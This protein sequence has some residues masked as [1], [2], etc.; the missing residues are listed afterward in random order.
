MP[1]EL[2]VVSI[3]AAN[4]GFL[5]GLEISQIRDYESQ[6]HQSLK[7]NSAKLLKIIQEK[8]SLSDEENQELLE[9]ISKFTENFLA[10]SGSS[11]QSA[12]Q[13]QEPSQK[14]S[15]SKPVAQRQA[16]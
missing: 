14:K 2:Q 7:A 9:E 15:E 1:V 4:G 12:Q 3:L 13:E 6:L 11:S 8:G 16:A 10:D 5:D